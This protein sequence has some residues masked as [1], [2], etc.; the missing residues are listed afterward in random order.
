MLKGYDSLAGQAWE[1]AKVIAV[2]HN[3]PLALCDLWQGV[4][5]VLDEDELATLLPEPVLQHLVQLRYQKV[6]QKVKV[7]EPVVIL[8]IRVRE[9][10]RAERR[11]EAT[12]WDMILALLGTDDAEIAQ[13]HREWG[14]DA[15]RFR[16]FAR[17]KLSTIAPSE[18]FLQPEAWEKLRPFVVNLTEQA[19]KGMLSPAYERDNE[20]TA[21]LLGLLGRSK[22]NV[23]LVG[24]AGVGKTKLVEDLALRIHRGELPQLRGCVVLALDLVSLRAGTSIH[25]EIE[26]RVKDLRTV[27]ERHGD[28]IILFIDE[29]HTIVG[30]PI[31]GMTLDIANSLKPLLASGRIRCIGATTRQEYVQH[32]EADH[33]LARRFQPV[34]IQEPSR[35]TME[36]ILQ[37]VKSNY[38]FHHGVVY[39]PE[40]VKAVLDLCERFMPMRHFPDK[41]I[42]LLDQAGA[43]ASLS[44]RDT[45]TTDDVKTV[46]AKRWNLSIDTLENMSV[47]EII[48]NLR[49]VVVGQEHALRSLETAILRALAFE[50]RAA[51]RAVWMFVGPPNVGKSLVART[52]AQLLCGNEKAFLQ[53]DIHSLARR[54]NTD[55]SDLDALV[56]VRPPY[57]GW[58]RGGM[59]TNH[60]IEFPRSVIL[61]RG[62]EGAS[63]EVMRFLESVFEEGTCTDGRGVQVSFHESF[64]ILVRDDEGKEQRLGFLHAEQALSDRQEG[65]DTAILYRQL[66]SSDFPKELLRYVQAIVLFKPLTRDALK[67][68]ARRKMEE[69]KQTVYVSEAKSLQYDERLLDLL[70]PD[71]E[72]AHSTKVV[73]ERIEHLV[74]LPLYRLKSDELSRW[75][76]WKAVFLTVEGAADS[77]AQVYPSQATPS[78]HIR[79]EGI[80]IRVVYRMD[81]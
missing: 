30:T 10:C 28:H 48:G 13:L 26:E 23:A 1:K 51:P 21:L 42:D 35:E 6:D 50:S 32:I 38:E 62:L 58:E 47:S 36:R 75:V 73:V 19:A 67:E 46:L 14:L 80:T 5:A 27:L 12:V 74:W 61:I 8:D 18:P 64:I 63:P 33:A 76:E 43:Y 34:T 3:R 55:A 56:G 66:Q 65:E 31:S 15:N 37:N 78:Y 16:E 17:S 72:E 44:Q 4:L 22:R 54:Y 69:V 77:T 29:L 20:R 2:A 45:V 79:D 41:A 52:L 68:I 60:V 70:L 49:Q 40:T 11:T 71:R 39:P 7:S 53:V 24:P 9:M 59:L 57:V 81:A 25:G